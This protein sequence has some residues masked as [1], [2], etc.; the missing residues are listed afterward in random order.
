MS[1]YIYDRFGKLIAE[2]YDDYR[3]AVRKEE[4]EEAT[5]VF[6]HDPS[7]NMSI[8]TDEELKELEEEEAEEFDDSDEDIDYDEYDQYYDDDDR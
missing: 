2:H 5:P 7:Q 1:K 6:S 8:Y 4:V 3:R